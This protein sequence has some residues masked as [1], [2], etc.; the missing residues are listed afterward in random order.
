[1]TRR[2]VWKS[3]S[4]SWSGS[5]YSG[6]VA[7]QSYPGTVSPGSAGGVARVD[8]RTLR[9]TLAANTGPVSTSGN[10]FDLTNTIPAPQGPSLDWKLFLHS[11]YD[12]NNAYVSDNDQITWPEGETLDWMPRI[13][14]TPAPNQVMGGET[15]RFDSKVI[16]W[17]FVSSE[18]TSATGADALGRSG[19]RARHKPHWYGGNDTMLDGC[20]YFYDIS[21][22]TTT[23]MVDELAQQAHAFWG[24]QTPQDIEPWTYVYQLSK[25]KR[26]EL[27]VQALV[28]VQTVKLANPATGSA[29]QPVGNPVFLKIEKTT[30]FYVN[31]VAPWA[32]G[33]SSQPRPV[34]R[35][36]TS[37]TTRSSSLRRIPPATSICL[38]TV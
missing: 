16:A 38:T 21:Y 5:A 23:A 33:P 17:S 3:A 14:S 18:G 32:V 37:R 8:N 35:S 34:A 31:L 1:M 36:A 29:E 26:V 11:R 10:R 30:P 22:A 2:S 28:K 20:A 4:T 19:C 15:Y 24:M 6:Y 25:L 13:A 7:N 27:R 12:G 9:L